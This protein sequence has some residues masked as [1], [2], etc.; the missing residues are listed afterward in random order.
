MRNVIVNVKC[1]L[2]VVYVK[3]IGVLKCYSHV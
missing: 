2:C 3:K 1:V